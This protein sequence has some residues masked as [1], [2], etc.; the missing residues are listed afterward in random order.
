MH[1]DNPILLLFGF[2]TLMNTFPS[3]LCGFMVF[4][5][6]QERLSTLWPKQDIVRGNMYCGGLLGGLSLLPSPEDQHLRTWG[7]P[8]RRGKA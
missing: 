4:P 6:I 7:K 5:R 3:E 2:R 8:R 1:A